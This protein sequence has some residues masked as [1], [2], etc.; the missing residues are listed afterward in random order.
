MSITRY[1]KSFAVA[2]VFVFSIPARA[3]IPV[4]DV[5]AIA[6]AIMQVQAWAQ[7]Y[8]QMV[9]QYTQLTT[10]TGKLDGARMLGT[11][12]NNPSIS[13]ALPA[14]MQNTAAMLANASVI[15]TSPAAL[16]SILNSFGVTGTG[17]VANGQGVADT[18][19]KMHSILTAAQQRQSQIGNLAS[20]VDSSSDAKD[21][22]DL[23]NRNVLENATINNQMM[24]TMATIEAAKQAEVLRLAARN[25]SHSAARKTGADAA[26]IN[27]SY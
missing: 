14:E 18:L 21:S 9:T 5:A 20:R 15:S 11:T 13:A 26:V 12:L 16:T 10:M 2:L 17:Y 4:I 24:Q 1:F 3:G 27:Y 6:Q 25:Q 8:Q 23:M 19:S 22:L 7:Q